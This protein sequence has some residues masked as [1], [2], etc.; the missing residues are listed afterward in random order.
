[1]LRRFG[2]PAL[3]PLALAASCGLGAPA[4]G[5]SFQHPR[6]VGVDDG[7]P[8]PTVHG[9][10]A[11]REGALWL[12]T[13]EGL[14]RYDGVELRT[15]GRL[16]GLSPPQIWSV[17]A[18]A[19]GRLWLGSHG[20]GLLM[21]VDPAAPDPW[22]A[23]GQM[24]MGREGL[25]R[26]SSWPAGRRGVVGR[27]EARAGGGVW[28]L[29]EGSLV[30][31]R[32]EHDRLILRRADDAGGI[33]LFHADRAGGEPW[34][35]RAGGGADRLERGGE[36]CALAPEIAA[37]GIAD[38]GSDSAGRLY[39]ASELAV[40]RARAPAARSCAALEWQALPL[41]LA[42]GERIRT[43][44]PRL[45][46]GLW[47]G[48]SLGLWR[49][50]DAAA[51][52][53]DETRGL[54]ADEV[55]SIHDDARAG[56][57]IGTLSNGLCRF[58]LEGLELITRGEGLSEPTFERT[59]EGRDGTLYAIS[60]SGWFEIRAEGLEPVAG[61]QN[62]PWRH[63]GGRIVADA[64]GF[65]IGTEAGLA[66]ID[67]PR[68]EPAR[69]KLLG[70]ESGLPPGALFGGSPMAGLAV[71]AEGVV[72]AGIAGSGLYRRGP[73]DQRFLAVPGPPS[74]GE[75]PPFAFVA[76]GAGELVTADF[77]GLRLL[78]ESGVETLELPGGSDARSFL[79]DRAGRLWIG[80][81]YGGLARV[82]ERR[83]AALRIESW[84]RSE[85]LVSD[86]VW[87]I[88]EDRFSRL[89]LCTGRGLS[90]FDPESEGI[91]SWTTADGL[92][93][94][95]LHHCFIDRS[96]QLWLAGR[97]GLARL[98]P[99]S[100]EPSSAPDVRWR[101]IV[102]GG[103]PLLLRESGNQEPARVTLGPGAAPLVV[104]V[105][106]T[107]FARGLR[108]RFRLEPPAEALWSDPSPER[109]VRY[110][111]LG[112]G[113]YRLSAL[114]VDSSGAESPAPALLEIEVLAPFWR[115]GW[116]VG[117]IALAMTGLGLAGHRLRLARERDIARVR[118]RLAADLHDDIGAGLARI[119]I[120]AEV[121]RRAAPGAQSAE[122]LARIAEGAR[123]LV[124][125]MADVV[126]ALR[127]KRETSADLVQKLHRYAHDT[128]AS[129][130][131]TL[132]F[133]SALPPELP[134]DAGQRRDLLLAGK[135]LLANVSRHAGARAVEIV[136]DHHKTGVELVVRDD[137]VGFTGPRSEGQGLPNLARRAARQ[138]GRF[139]IRALPSG[140]TEARFEV[141][142]A[143]RRDSP[144]VQVGRFLRG[145]R[146]IDES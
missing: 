47:V 82:V 108:F 135:E 129:Q 51:R 106:G 93:A 12:A 144:L 122:R 20:L 104:R 36:L 67:G 14:A 123:E 80:R 118:E 55:L 99:A 145:R 143:N 50:E 75:A 35:V 68:L 117:S 88:A 27:V 101:E 98:D 100:L 121:S 112:P 116:F 25:G 29:D 40:H 131:L 5:A 103:E 49:G 66:R 141:A 32:P 11:D 90:R 114:A 102:A 3:I 59:V 24:L 10:V 31:A 43:V 136:L 134:L 94:G 126:W 79:R 65:W 73:G 42:P 19:E 76:A 74:W 46:G 54:P 64:D 34:I 72:W 105:T 26:F 2:F 113:R 23:S 120:L 85:G 18:D 6:C 9:V 83:G 139:E 95:P 53:A 16:D 28:L 33:V 70:E 45:R 125:A 41:P 57:S 137:G 39:V 38:L 52:Q 48:T 60:E 115:R 97:G 13:A 146:R 61:S 132:R 127:P 133:A 124:E 37:A 89:W 128:I 7:L 111:G 30:E 15:F 62:D 17:A 8:S 130:D 109:T 71:D 69:A 110:A 142:T 81:R 92:P 4:W 140:G 77:L 84:T 56:L 138:G 44:A 91:E 21:L 86:A 1:M 63:A 78:S 107:P 58:P 119:A 96:G 87:S 22:A